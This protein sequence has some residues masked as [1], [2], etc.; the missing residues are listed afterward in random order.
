MQ[1][2]PLGGTGIQASRIAL[3]AWAIGGW[4]W[5]PQ[6]DEE[7]V[8]SIQA[9]I[10]SGITLID[11]A[12]V[13]GFGRSEEVVGRAIAGRR[14]EEVVIA[15]K[16]GMR[17]DLDRGKLFFR[18]SED[19]IDPQGKTAVHVYA[20]PESV[21]EEVERSL[22][23]LQIEHIDLIQTHWQDETTPIA[24][25][26][27]ELLRLKAEGKVRAIG[28]CN[29]S[30]AQMDEY[31]AVGS[32]DSDQ[33]RFSLID[34]Q[35][36]G[37]K[38]PYCLGHNLAFLAYSPLANGL[39]TGKMG[40]DRVFPK[41]DMRNVR[42]R[43]AVESRRMV[44][45]ALNQICPMAESRGVSLAQLIIAWTLGQPGVTHVLVGART[46][47]QARENAV[48]ASIALTDE[49]RQR[50][51]GIAGDLGDRVGSVAPTSSRK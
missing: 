46:P 43:F 48:A 24:D 27:G 31:R 17:W 10:D 51:A 22:R 9:A 44:T 49:E 20:S 40:P 1:S 33:D 38:L 26:M 8:R 16:V 29:A 47:E 21:R 36:E 14:R 39:L 15:T 34:R 35:A 30:P 45:E 5:G 42:P 7:S 19:E 2:L 11:T 4:N 32:L 23:R 25:T 13:Y 12:P 6:D 41:G 50:I 37:E 18:S 3:G 28:V